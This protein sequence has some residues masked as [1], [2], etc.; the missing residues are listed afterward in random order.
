LEPFVPASS[1]LDTDASSPSG[2]AAGCPLLTARSGCG[3][4]V[5]AGE[6]SIAAGTV[7]RPKAGEALSV[8]KGKGLRSAPKTRSQR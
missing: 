7:V 5:T 2:T 3:R 4:V 8:G 6:R 1:P